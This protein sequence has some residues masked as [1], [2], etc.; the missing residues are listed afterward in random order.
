MIEDITGK[1]IGKSIGEWKVNV[2]EIDYKIE[3]IVWLIFKI[4]YAKQKSE[5]YIG[6]KNWP[7]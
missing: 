3:E 2:D 5:D 4:V 7:T 1:V 6:V